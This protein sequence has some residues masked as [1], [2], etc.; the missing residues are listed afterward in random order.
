MCLG[1][2]F[3]PFDHAFLVGLTLCLM[4]TLPQVELLRD[5]LIEWARE[6]EKRPPSMTAEECFA[7]LG[8][9]RNMVYDEQYVIAFCVLSICR[10]PVVGILST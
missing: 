7:L 9:P 5:I 6:V 3:L 1:C 2:A 4:S 8:L 10:I